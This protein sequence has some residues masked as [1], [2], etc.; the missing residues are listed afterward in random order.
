MISL[1]GPAAATILKDY[2]VITICYADV[3]KTHANG[4]TNISSG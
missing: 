2:V 3:E 4:K 1:V